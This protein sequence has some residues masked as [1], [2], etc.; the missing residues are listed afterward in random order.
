MSS[1][2]PVYFSVYM[3]MSASLYHYHLLLL[4][5]GSLCECISLYCFLLIFHLT[6]PSF[7][8]L[9][10]SL[11]CSLS[12]RFF[13]E[14]PLLFQ[15][16]ERYTVLYTDL[17]LTSSVTA[18]NSVSSIISN[19]SLVKEH[20][21]P[22]SISFLEVLWEE[23]SGVATAMLMAVIVETSYLSGTL[24]SSLYL[25]PR[26]SIWRGI[27]PRGRMRHH[28]VIWLIPDCRTEPVIKP[29]SLSWYMHKI[30]KIICLI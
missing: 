20:K 28:M 16:G 6:Y 21:S 11:T 23:Y 8:S 13:F 24:Y 30:L 9:W 17:Y 27:W 22:P 29:M 14:L 4:L 26:Y 19:C 18:A 7:S 25:P 10:I 1:L 5:F 12:P 3:S 15:L 2:F